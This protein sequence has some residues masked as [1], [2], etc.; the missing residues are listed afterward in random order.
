MW[1]Q[2][3]NQKRVVKPELNVETSSKCN[4]NLNLVGK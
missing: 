2:L 4:V 1:N 3:N